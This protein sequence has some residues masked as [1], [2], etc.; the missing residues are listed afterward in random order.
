MSGVYYGRT[1]EGGTL[2]NGNYGLVNQSQMADESIVAS[3]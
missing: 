3:I 2:P 1:C